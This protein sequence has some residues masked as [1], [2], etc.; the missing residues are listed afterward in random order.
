M[1]KYPV[2][3]AVSVLGGCLLLELAL[4]YMT[5]HI[6]Q[7]LLFASEVLKFCH[8]N[9]NLQH[10]ATIHYTPEAAALVVPS[11]LW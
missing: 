4:V 5:P 7:H 3:L 9:V 2:P 1:G 8:F 10:R 6:N 11:P